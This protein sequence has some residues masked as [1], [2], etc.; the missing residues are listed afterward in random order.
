MLNNRILKHGDVLK[1]FDSDEFKVEIIRRIKADG[2]IEYGGYDRNRWMPYA[3]LD[4]MLLQ[5]QATVICTMTP[6]T[7]IDTQSFESQKPSGGRKKKYSP[8]PKADKPMAYKSRLELAEKFKQ[9]EFGQ[10]YRDH[11]P[12]SILDLQSFKSFERH[13]VS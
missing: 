3:Q 5:G 11:A 9:T 6:K 12:A 8:K 1:I 10:K 2:A 7:Q 4:E 13:H